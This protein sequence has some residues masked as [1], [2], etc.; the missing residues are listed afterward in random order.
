[1]PT[2]EKGAANGDLILLTNSK[3]A[4]KG[5]K[6][7]LEEERAHRADNTVN[8]NEDASLL[9]TSEV[10]DQA[11]DTVLK[12]GYENENEKASPAK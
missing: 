4:P 3:L 1:M 8:P 5:V 11:A 10:Y 2:L 9:N 12:D 6:T 7:V